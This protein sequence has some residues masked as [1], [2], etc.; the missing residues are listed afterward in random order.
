MINLY[1]LDCTHFPFAPQHSNIL[2]LFKGVPQINV[3]QPSPANMMGTGTLGR[4]GG[5]VS[6][7]PGGRGAP[8]AGYNKM[9]SGPKN[10]GSMESLDSTQSLTL[11]TYSYGSSTS[12]GQSLHLFC[13]YYFV[14]FLEILH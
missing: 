9:T 2:I 5:G 13:C 14:L 7:A 10:A 12:T 11:S 4:G 1:Y 8:A 3:T 6:F